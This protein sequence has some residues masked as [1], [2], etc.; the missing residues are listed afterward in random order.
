MAPSDMMGGRGGAQ[1][2]PSGVPMPL[3]L[4]HVAL[5]LAVAIA[6]GGLIGLERERWARK[7]SKQTFGGARTY[8]LIALAGGLS[9]LI[10]QAVGGWALLAGFGAFVG[11]LMVGIRSERA[12]AQP[13]TD[14]GLTSEVAA[15]LV[16]ACGTL[17]FL[18]GFGL[19]TFDE[20]LL[21]TAGVGAVVFAIL[22]LREPAHAF[23][24]A[25]SAEDVRA[26][27][28]FVLLAVVVLPL[29]PRQSMGPFG[30]FNPFAAGL[31]VVLIA[32]ISFLGYAAVR[33]L[34]A[35]R[36]I[37]LTALF[38]GLAS[39]TAVTLSFSARGKEHPSL[40]SACALAIVLASTIM[41]PRMAVEIGVIRPALLPA[42]ALPLGAM[43]AV[44]AAG[45]VLLWLRAGRK[46]RADGDGE[47]PRFNNPFS[48]PQA[49]KLGATY[50]AVRFVAAG[51][52]HL[53]GETG[54]YASAALSGL[55]DVDAITISIGRMHAAG[56][57][58]REAV[59]AVALAAASNTFT[60]SLLAL[61]LGGRS[62]GLSVAAVLIPAGLAGLL[63]SLFAG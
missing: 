34:G 59:T 57:G 7:E 42:V 40:A 36:G 26:T 3:D 50:V 62:L 49:L 4:Q 52:Y 53:F 45:C 46:P 25:L 22:S 30:F 12:K 28:Q 51:A 19:P 23:A 54:L 1:V 15:L 55:T 5:G 32:G 8:P 43:V 56:L 20:R 10:A 18:E 39:S 24:E 63:V 61:V 27:M 2:G 11:L 6:V 13:G 14:I 21:L 16:F 48:L 9:S 37:G 17:P 60:K 33:L 38:G 47:A 29:L 31:V 35:R 41:F 44:G 58:T